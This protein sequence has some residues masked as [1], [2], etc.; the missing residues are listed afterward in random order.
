MMRKWM[1]AGL[2]GALSL[3]GQIAVADDRGVQIKNMDGADAI[4][5]VVDKYDGN[6]LILDHYRINHGETYSVAPAFGE[7]H[8]Y[9]LQW[10]AE[11]TSDHKS[12]DGECFG[13][14]T[15]CGIDLWNAR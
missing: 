15:P 8:S 11:R 4:V 1:I 6:R 10:H 12:K 9:D 14:N 5:S 3:I 13:Q 2:V 7:D